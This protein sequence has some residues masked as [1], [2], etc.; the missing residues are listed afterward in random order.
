MP[1][2]NSHTNSNSIGTKGLSSTG[3][4]FPVHIFPPTFF[5]FT[6]EKGSNSKENQNI[7]QAT[8]PAHQATAKVILYSEMS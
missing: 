6:N 1:I 2:S 5:K 7:N 8:L 4:K 3:M